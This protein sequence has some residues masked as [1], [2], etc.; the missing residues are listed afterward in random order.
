MMNWHDLL[1]T[2]RIGDKEGKAPG[3][4]ESPFLLDL[5]RITFSSFFRRLQDKTQ[6]HPL[7]EGGRVRSRLT[8]SIEVASVGRSLGFGVGRK[9]IEAECGIPDHITA[10]DF[11]YIVQVACLSHDIGNPPFGHAGEAAIQQWFIDNPDV[12]DDTMSEAEKLDF[13]KFEGNAQGFR[14]LNKL[15]Y[16][17][18]NGGF[19]MSHATLGAFTKYPGDATENSVKAIEGKK[20]GFCQSEKDLFAEVANNLGLIKR[21]SDTLWCR[22]PLA[23]LMEAADDICYRVA[24]LEDG[25]TM[26]CVSFKDVE[27]HLAPLAWS[28]KHGETIDLRRSDLLAQGWYQKMSEH[29]KLGFLRSKAIGNLTKATVEAFISNE[30][31]LLAGRFN[32]ELLAV[33]PFANEA[34]ACKKFA[35]ESIFS[36]RRKLEIETSS[37]EVLNV[38]LSSFTRA[39]LELEVCGG[40]LKQVS[41]RSKRLLKMMENSNGLCT[42]RYEYLL[43]V[44][45]FI[46]GLSDRSAVSLCNVIRGVSI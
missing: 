9:L 7:S 22:H 33:T 2:K 4:E 3:R 23:Y 38:L 18:G 21:G 5:D 34:D 46:S 27:Y 17:R 29:E 25:V 37:F 20:A 15:D 16:F 39:V 31:A 1:S 11:G 36:T 24:D 44:T 43:K 35:G 32:D 45:D 41:E 40:E 19:Q 12:F 10:H 30:E 14:I 6:V 42:C 28:H 8:H 26:D 13:T